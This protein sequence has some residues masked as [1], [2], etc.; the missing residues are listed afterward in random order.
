M[1]DRHPCVYI[2]ASAPDGTLYV[3]VT[4][5]LPARI[6]QHRDGTF[7]GFAAEH[8][9]HCLVYFEVHDTMA[10]AIARE[11]QLKRYRRDWKRNLIERDNPRWD[12]LGPAIGLEPLR[13]KKKAR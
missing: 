4:A 2:L 7:G 3:G 9:V 6:T 5:D 12:D 10:D 13:S 1:R 11:K 8:G